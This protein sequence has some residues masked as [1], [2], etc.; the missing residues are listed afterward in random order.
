M[1]GGDQSR[2]FADQAGDEGGGF[3][4]AIARGDVAS[5]HPDDALLVGMRGKGG[6]RGPLQR[7]GFRVRQTQAAVRI[8]QGHQPC[9]G[10]M[11][12]L[13]DEAIGGVDDQP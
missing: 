1:L 7:A 12:A 3:G 6:R 13:G 9:E 2:R 11:A 10:G 8:G 5:P 4:A